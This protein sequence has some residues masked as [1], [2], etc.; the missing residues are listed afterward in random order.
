MTI[1]KFVAWPQYC[2]ETTNAEFN[3]LKSEMSVD[4][5]RI[6][7]CSQERKTNPRQLN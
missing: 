5:I 2:C 4:S 3:V 1:D 7:I 6:K